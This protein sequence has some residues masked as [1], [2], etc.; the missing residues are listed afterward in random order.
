MRRDKIGIGGQRL[1]LWFGADADIPAV[2]SIKAVGGP[3][4]S[5]APS[6]PGEWPIAV[7]RLPKLSRPATRV[8][9]CEGELA[10][11]GRAVF[12][13]PSSA[14]PVEAPF[15]QPF[16]VL[17]WMDLR[18]STD[19]ISHVGVDGGNGA[20]LAFDLLEPVEEWFTVGAIER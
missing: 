15:A 9:G 3:V 13:G 17:V 14:S 19:Q 7:P 10:A 16:P 11:L 12:N 4:K 5:V 18:Q 2:G 1:A 8:L 20:M 6:R